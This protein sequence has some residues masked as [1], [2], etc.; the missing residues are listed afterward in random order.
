[1]KLVDVMMSGDRIRVGEK[2]VTL[3]QR[4]PRG[5]AQ[6]GVQAIARRAN[7]NQKKCWQKIALQLSPLPSE[8]GYVSV[9]NGL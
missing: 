7:Q 1:M 8:A 5:S 9:K 3:I 6:S 4:M 2:A